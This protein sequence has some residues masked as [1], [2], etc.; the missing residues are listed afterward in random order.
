MHSLASRIVN[1]LNFPLPG[2]AKRKME[3]RDAY[4][5]FASSEDGRLIL[6]DLAM[7]YGT[8][9]CLVPGD[10]H[11]TH[12]NLGAFR[13]LRHIQAAGAVSDEQ[14]LR[15]VGAMQRA[16]HRADEEDSVA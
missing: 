10:S 3:L 14:I 9:D 11:A 15:A 6:A 2:R 8:G 12:Y 1:A 4:R 7:T 16:D 13:V 5:R